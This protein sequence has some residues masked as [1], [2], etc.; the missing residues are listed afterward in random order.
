MK[1]KIRNWLRGLFGGV[2]GG[3]ANAVL[4]AFGIAGAAAINDNITPLDLRH[5]GIMFAS[6]AIIST[7]MFLKD[8][9]LPPSQNGDTEITS[10]PNTK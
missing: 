2:I 5:V 10:K 3:G 9:P 7:M 4:S 1:S 8:S 6:G